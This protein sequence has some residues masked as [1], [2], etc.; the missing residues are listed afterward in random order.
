MKNSINLFAL[1]SRSPHITDRFSTER[2]G[3]RSAVDEFIRGSYIRWFN[4]GTL[5]VS[6]FQP[7][8][9]T[10][11]IS[12]G[13]GSMTILLDTHSP[14]FDIDLTNNGSFLVLNNLWPKREKC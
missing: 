13:A 2:N 5:Y 9:D 8:I 14:E 11:N 6:G 12:I 3:G 10:T 7:I 1:R 4:Q